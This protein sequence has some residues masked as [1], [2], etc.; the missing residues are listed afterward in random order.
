MGKMEVSLPHFM[1]MRTSI[2]MRLNESHRRQ[3]SMLFPCYR[4]KKADKGHMSAFAKRSRVWS[5]ERKRAL[6]LRQP[7]TSLASEIVTGR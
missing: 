5:M 4:E 6:W 7:T 2:L 3:Y 1:E